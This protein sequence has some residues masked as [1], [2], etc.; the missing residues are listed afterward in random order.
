MI[1]ATGSFGLCSGDVPTIAQLVD[2][3]DDELF[4]K[5]YCATHITF[6]T[7]HCR[8]KQSRSMNL[9][10]DHTSENL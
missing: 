6:C 7:T 2:R 10:T 9:D 4:E 5:V 1:Q 8:I 3:A